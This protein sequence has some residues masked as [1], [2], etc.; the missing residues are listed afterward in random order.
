M[1]G[2]E[3]LGDKKRLRYIM[4]LLVQAY[5]DKEPDELGVDILRK[6]IFLQLAGLPTVSATTLKSLDTCDVAEFFAQVVAGVQALESTQRA[7]STAT[8]SAAPGGAPIVSAFERST[9][10]TRDSAD[11][12]ASAPVSASA[13][14]KNVTG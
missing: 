3:A 1:S 9:A 5:D 11:A 6:K 13:G 10:G 7:P 8:S 12:R 14:V 4:E 2:E